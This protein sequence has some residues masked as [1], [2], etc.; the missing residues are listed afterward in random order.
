MNPENFRSEPPYFTPDGHLTEESIAWLTDC[1]ITLTLDQLPEEVTMHVEDC[2]YCKEIIH[3]AKEIQ[4]ATERPEAIVPETKPEYSYS[5]FK[6]GRLIRVFQI[7][8]I[9]LILISVSIGLIYEFSSTRKDNKGRFAIIDKKNPAPVVRQ[10]NTAEKQDSEPGKIREQTGARKKEL[11]AASFKPAPHL[12]ILI[13]EAQ[14]SENLQVIA[15][16]N[17]V[18][19]RNKLVFQ[20][21]GTDSPVTIRIVSN[22]E[23]TVDSTRVTGNNYV[24]HKELK[25]GL[26]YW[27]LSIDREVVYIGKFICQ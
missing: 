2:A 1:L 22:T 14:R 8:A 18:F 25:P 4:L 27:L 21:K 15:P 17:N 24:L 7:A 3:A 6:K 23:K 5:K 20:W 19:Y 10:E 12:E 9:G 13:S 11:L 16:E 26:Y